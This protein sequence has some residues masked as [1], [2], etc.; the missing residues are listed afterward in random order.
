MRAAAL[1]I[2]AIG[3]AACAEPAPAPAPSPPPGFGGSVPSG[4][5]QGRIDALRDRPV[6]LGVM[7][8]TEE[9]WTVV[10]FA[11]VPSDATPGWQGPVVRIRKGAESRDLH[12]QDDAAVDRFVAQIEGAPA[13]K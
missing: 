7:G 5:A 1:L 12:L 6:P 3:L 9:G 10:G 11:V 4:P 8:V 13:K 2:A